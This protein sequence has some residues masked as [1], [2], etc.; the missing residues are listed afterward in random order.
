MCQPVISR[1]SQASQGRFPVGLCRAGPHTQ[2]ERVGPVTK[3]HHFPTHTVR[4]T[5]TLLLQ[6]TPCLLPR[7]P[8]PV[9]RLAAFSRDRRSMPGP[10]RIRSSY[11]S[12]FVQA[13]CIFE[14]MDTNDQLSCFRSALSILYWA[15]LNILE[16]CS[17]I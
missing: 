7:I 4:F 12:L 5:R 9:S 17:L 15:Y 3:C 2:T 13:L 14:S 1:I 10:L 8:S 16:A 11:R 6:L